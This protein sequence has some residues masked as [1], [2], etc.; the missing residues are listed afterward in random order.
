MR[1]W[2]LA[3]AVTL[4]GCTCDE[5]RC[6]PTTCN[7]CCSTE[8]VCVEGGLTAHCGVNG[9][10]C[11]DCG[12]KACIAGAC[13]DQ[14]CDPTSCPADKVCQRDA[15]GC[16]PRPTCNADGGGCPPDLRCVLA[17]GLCAPHCAVTADCP[18]SAKNCSGN[19]CHCSTDAICSGRDAG[20]LVCD[21]AGKLCL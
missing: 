2:A 13:V 5:R 18:L 9:G 17:L 20:K 19:I 4:G 10:D 21:P 8:D 15:G 16:V 7:G 6:L 11:I 12:S 1:L 3:L 14:S